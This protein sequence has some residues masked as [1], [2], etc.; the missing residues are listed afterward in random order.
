VFARFGTTWSQQAYLKASNTPPGRGVGDNFGI[1]VAVSG[2]TVV[3]GAEGEDSSTTGV[4]SAP[5]EGAT[6]SG[7]AYV[8]VRTSGTWSQ[9]A[10]LKASNTGSGDN[11][12]RS[13]SV[14][15]DTL[16]VGAWREDSGTTGVNSMPDEER[17]DSGAAYVFV[18]SG[19]DWS[20]QA[21]L[22]ANSSGVDDWF[23]FSVSVSADTVVVGAYLEDSAAMGV[24]GTPDEAATNSGAAYVFTRSGGSWSQQ[25]YLKA[26]NTDSHDYFGQSVSV[27]ADT[28]V[29]GAPLEDTL[30][31]DDSGAAYVF[32][33]SGTT[34]S[35][36]AYLKASNS[37][38]GDEFG[39]SVAV[40]GDT[41]VVG[42]A[43]E[44]SNATG[45][46]GN[47]TGIIANSGAAYV[48]V[49]SGVTWSQEAYLKAESP[50]V[51]DNFGSSVSASGNTAVVGANNEDS[52]TTGVN[53]IPDEGATNSGATYVFARSGATWSQQA[54][55]KASNTGAGDLFGSSVSVSGDT[56]VVGALR[57]GGS[58]SGVNSSPDDSA[59]DSGAA[60]IFTGLGPVAEVPDIV[61]EQSGSDVPTGS[62]HPFGS[63]A[64]G[65]SLDRVFSILNTGTADLTLSGSPKVAPSGSADFSITSQP[66]ITDIPPGGSGSFTVRFTPTGSGAKSATLSIAN[67]DG[68]E[69]PFIIQLT[70]TATTASAL[71]T[72]TMT[73]GTPLT[74]DDALP[75]ATPFNDGVEN[76]L[77]Y[78]FNMNLAGPDANTLPPGAGTSGLPSITTPAAAPTGT[79]RFEFL[80]RK[81]SGLVYMPQ[82]STSLD[83]TGWSPLAATPVVMS[84]DDQWERVVYTEAPDPVPAPACFGRVEV[85]IP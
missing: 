71:F 28:I 65:S 31:N 27:S 78:A 7:A 59:A 62:T 37:G 8:F 1:S 24:N 84:I 55:L 79:L 73:S 60:Y 32:A 68:D 46:N 56:V 66:A 47:E 30:P 17:T 5:N 42:A 82:K 25:A 23:G 6:N 77:K 45:V 64:T 20:Q 3:V 16:V 12:G 52:N 85:V 36:Q 39:K 38:G 67:N 26:L 49:R 14:N 13:V 41:V 72:N 10:Y 80:R 54:Y 43:G 34:W 18:R 61:I 19:G 44:D 35:Q 4:N 75:N 50:G 70:G 40:S 15:G 63:V 22:K 69:N 9:Q 51:D 2:D 29:I 48:F 57:E 81:G 33:R 11:F 58:S 83:G 76:L 53:S 21:Y 74:G